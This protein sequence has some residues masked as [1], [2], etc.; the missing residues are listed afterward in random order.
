MI[1]RLITA[2]LLV[3]ATA[4]FAQADVITTQKTSRLPA[5]ILPNAMDE[6]DPFDPNIEQKLEDMDRIYEQET[7]LSAIV[8]DVSATW[9]SCRQS[10]C[11]VWIRIDKSKQTAYLYKYGRHVDTWLVSSGVPGRGTPNF[12]GRPNGRIYDRYTS[13]KY[14]EG[15]YKGLGNMPYAVFYKGGFAIHGTTVGN[16]K[17]LGKKASHGCIRVHPDNGF[18]FNRLVRQHGIGNVWISIYGN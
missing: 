16:F 4:T 10:S 2:I 12:E 13:T 17:R 3:T 14:P 5:T 9:A 7:G 8:E 1:N 11:A 6:L 15:D 18:T